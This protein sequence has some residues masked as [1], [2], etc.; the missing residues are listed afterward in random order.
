MIKDALKQFDTKDEK[1]S[2]VLFNVY[3]REMDAI[4]DV[5]NKSSI[6][7]VVVNVAVCEHKNEDWKYDES[8]VDMYC[9][10]CKDSEVE[11]CDNP[12]CEDGI[13]DYDYYKN[14]IYC[15]V[16]DKHN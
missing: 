7:N 10:K 16:C 12:N 6:S 9:T 14:P 5:V 3:G 13:V 11:L 8:G 4:I 15:Q 2:E 1:V